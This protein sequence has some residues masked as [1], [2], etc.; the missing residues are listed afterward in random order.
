V[1]DQ[2]TPERDGRRRSPTILD[3]AREA[4]VSKT[5]VSRVLNDSP[6]VADDTQERVKQ[7]MK[8]LG[9]RVNLAARSLR[10]T[11][12]ALV[13]LLVPTIDNE[14]F[15][16]VAQ[17]LTTELANSSIG[18]VIS[19]SNWDSRAELRALQ[20]LASRGVDA[21]A[22]SLVNDQYPGVVE[23]VRSFERPMVLLDRHV[24]GL[25]A[26]T[27]VTDQRTGLVA[28]M[29]HLHDLGHRKIGLVT[30]PN[31]TRTTR[32]LTASYRAAC[33][34]LGLPQRSQIVASVDMASGAEAVD[35]LLSD[36]LRAIVVCAPSL[37]L[38]GA[39]ERLDALGLKVPADV[40]IVGYDESPVAF[41]KR[42]RLTVISRD[43]DEISQA[44]S[45]MIVTRLSNPDLPPRLETVHT[46]L[47]IRDS[48]GPVP[49][50]P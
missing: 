17:T 16:R 10:T 46:E 22:L 27:V 34:R 29:T 18:L 37:V 14:I 40:S 9:F 3:L 8:S 30:L 28:T 19:T 47:R 45:R 38:A 13:G 11:R 39:L 48:S 7:A 26:D 44:A 23:F 20:S 42:P 33:R 6:K 50:T 1:A 15:G 31:H 43:I 36:G 32:E 5:T 4:G 35:R 2:V 41:A 49:A 25:S 21:L 12:S 24:P